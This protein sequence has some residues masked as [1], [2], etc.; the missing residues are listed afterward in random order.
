MRAEIAALARQA[1]IDLHKLGLWSGSL[2]ALEKLALPAAETIARFDRSL[3]DAQA[4]IARL[5]GQ[6]EK[7]RVDSA[8][9]ERDLERLRLE[10]EVPSEAELVEARKLRDAGWQLVLQ[11]WRKE[12]TDAAALQRLSRRRRRSQRSGGGLRAD[13]P[14]G[15]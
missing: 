5:Q 7:A 1:A 2:E 6:W 9:I 15:R 3:S 8:D 4:V 10:G 14:P 12:A 11:D 13:R